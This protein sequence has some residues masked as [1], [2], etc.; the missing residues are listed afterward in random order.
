ML[1]PILVNN[2][3]K[4]S[5][6]GIKA[7]QKVSAEKA[8]QV[9]KKV[10]PELMNKLKEGIKNAIQFYFDKKQSGGAIQIS[11][12]SWASFWAGFKATLRV[13]G[14]LAL[15]YGA[16]VAAATGHPVL[17][18]ALTAVDSQIGWVKPK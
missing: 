11:G 15:K 12:G 18:A 13:V 3:V 1:L 17:S 14:K 9:V 16:K 5:G 6:S 7:V 10:Q 2:E 4:Q 8:K